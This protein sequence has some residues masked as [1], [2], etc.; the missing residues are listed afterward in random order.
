MKARAVFVTLL[1]A[2]PFALA[3]EPGLPPWVGRGAGETADIPMPGWARTVVPQRVEVAVYT[4]PG[5]APGD[6]ATAPL[7]RR[8]TL[9]V[10]ARVPFFGAQR[11]PH[12]PG[13]WYNIGALAWVCSDNVDLSPEARSPSLLPAPGPDGLPFRYYFVGPNGA[14]AYPTFEHAGDEAP[15]Q[16]LEKGWSLP[17]VEQR[18]KGGELWG[19]SR[20]GKWIN[21]SEL[22]L[23]RPLAF[24]GTEIVNGNLV[25][26]WV[27][28]DTAPTFADASGTKR[29]SETLVRFQPVRIFDEKRQGGLLYLR[30]SEDGAA[31]QWVRATHIARPTLA[32]PPG[33]VTGAE[34]GERWID[35]ELSSQTLTAYEGKVPVFSTLVSTGKGARGTDTATPPGVHRIWVKLFTTPMANLEKPDV[36]HYYSIEDV[37]YVQF[38]DK[39]VALHAAFWHRNLG[40]VQSHG[41]VNLAPLDAER[42]FHFTGPH[43]PNGWDAALPTALEPGTWVRVRL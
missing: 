29:A 22:G 12:C 19:R 21:M 5:L 10:G 37:P 16:T 20:A 42:L 13:R 32:A 2:S 35:V 30:V 25:V 15:D 24:K 34:L 43:L 26:G 8:G 3:D 38:F 11:G 31:P 6:A 17:I 40:R 14:T 4:M 27:T 36:E 9:S 28:A 23:S 33:E 41:C 39:G 1:F 18:R 7:V